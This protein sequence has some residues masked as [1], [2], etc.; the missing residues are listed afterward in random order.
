M[1]IRFYARKT[2]ASFRVLS[3]V[4]PVNTMRDNESLGG[5]WLV[6]LQIRDV[7]KILDVQSVKWQTLPN[8]GRSNKGIRD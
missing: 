1:Q 3:F 4:A 8:G 5:S 6:E 2:P 7:V